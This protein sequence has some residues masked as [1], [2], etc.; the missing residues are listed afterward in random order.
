M[1][2]WFDFWFFNFVFNLVVKFYHSKHPVLIFQNLGS[3][4][5]A[6]HL[7]YRNIWLYC[8]H[9]VWN[10][11]WSLYQSSQMPWFLQNFP[12]IPKFCFICVC[13]LKHFPHLCFIVQ[14]FVSFHSI[15]RCN[16]AIKWALLTIWGQC[17]WLPL[18]VVSCISMTQI[19][20]QVWQYSGNFC[21]LEQVIDDLYY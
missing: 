14:S 9:T 11:V 16:R 13:F 6:L 12:F 4:C 15:Q 17:R 2:C 7:W 1:L 5:K 10:I 18:L 3:W 8:C 21:Q 20:T 19:R